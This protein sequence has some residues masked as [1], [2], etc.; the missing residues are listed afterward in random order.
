MLTK[1]RSYWS[2]TVSGLFSWESSWPVIG[3]GTA[4]GSVDRD[5][6]VVRGA[7][8]NGKSYMIGLSPLQYKNAVILPQ[9][10]LP[11]YH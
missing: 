7:A 3:S 11:T 1:S 10:A 9:L 4:A 8:Q 5:A 6:V 2:N